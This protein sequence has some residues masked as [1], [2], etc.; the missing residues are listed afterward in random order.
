MDYNKILD[1]VAN[2]EFY[3]LIVFAGGYFVSD[4]YYKIY[5]V[6]PLSVSWFFIII[7]SLIALLFIFVML[8]LGIYKYKMGRNEQKYDE[9]GGIN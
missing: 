1:I 4:E 9:L 5:H 7:I 6:M 3:L 8:P 2:F